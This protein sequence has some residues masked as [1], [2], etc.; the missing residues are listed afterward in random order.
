MKQGTH[1]TNTTKPYEFIGFG[2]MDATK[3]YEL[4]GFGAMDATKPC[5]FIGFGAMDAT[6]PYEF[7]GFG[8]LS[9]GAFLFRA[10]ET[11][12]YQPLLWIFAVFFFFDIFCDV[13]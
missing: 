3:P 7:I 12:T 13:F 8:A 1:P 9:Q 2:A 11:P 6:K 4:I 5:E 10:Y